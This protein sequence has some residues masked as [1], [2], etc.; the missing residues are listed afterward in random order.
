MNMRQIPNM[1]G[2]FRVILTPLLVYLLLLNTGVSLFAAAW[3]LLAMA[4]SD[5]IDG[6]LARSYGVVSN[7]GI[8]LD[9]ISDKIFVAGALLPMVETGL[10]QSWYALIIIAREFA[11]SGLRSYAAAQGIVIPARSWGKQKLTMTVTG[12][13]WL[14]CYGGWSGCHSGGTF[15]IRW[16]C[17]GR[18]VQG[19]S[20]FGMR[21]ICSKKRSST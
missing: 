13:I 14:M 8:F 5:I 3:V 9:T 15:P 6:R 18:W 10:V 7:L 17:F 16:R 1:L 20:I 2:L 4:I 12:L 21:A 19:L 11:V